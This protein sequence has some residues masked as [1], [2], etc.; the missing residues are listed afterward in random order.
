MV[1]LWAT[2]ALGRRTSFASSLDDLRALEEKLM[3]PRQESVSEEAE[4]RSQA[5]AN[6]ML[7][8]IEGNSLDLS[9]EPAKGQVTNV[10]RSCLQSS[11]ALKQALQDDS[12]DPY[13]MKS[14][15]KNFGRCSEGGSTLMRQ[16][17]VAEDAPF[18][19]HGQLPGDSNKKTLA[20]KPWSDAS[21]ACDTVANKAS[22]VASTPSDAGHLM[23]EAGHCLAL[24]G[25]A[26]V[27][28]PVRL[29]SVGLL[30]I[31]A[32]PPVTQLEK[33]RRRTRTRVGHFL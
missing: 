8:R 32:V 1:C 17:F 5:T 13:E 3:E 28:T 15:L 18:S 11:L 22:S 6:E 31:A 7:P 14:I 29:S 20:M 10:V 9:E 33:V 12:I 25:K 16:L 24:L 30:G 2:E 27:T 21:S 26:M 4:A 19:F 23:T